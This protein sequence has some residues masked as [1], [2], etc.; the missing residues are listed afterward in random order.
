M[1]N[2]TSYLILGQTAQSLIFGRAAQQRQAKEQR[3]MMQYQADLQEYQAKVARQEAAYAKNIHEAEV[4]RIHRNFLRGQGRERSLLAANG[5]DMQSEGA[6]ELLMGHAG[7]AARD[8]EMARYQG[9]MQSWRH[10]NQYRSHSVQA[11]HLR[12]QAG[13]GGSK[14]LLA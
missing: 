11:D 14:G 5:V 7:Q 2:I 4:E 10:M 12:K 8:E 1:C 3:A 6:L 13:K 9:E